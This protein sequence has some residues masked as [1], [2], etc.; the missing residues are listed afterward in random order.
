MDFNF[1]KIINR[2]NTNTKAIDI[3]PIPT[4][5]IKEGFSLIPMWVADMSFETVPTVIEEIENRINHSLFGYFNLPKEYFNSIINWQKNRNNIEDLKVGNIGYENGVLGGLSTSLRALASVGDSILVHSPTYIGFSR[6]LQNNGYNMVLSDLYLDEK[7]IWRMDYE[8]MERKIKENNIHLAIFCSP[9]N[10]SGRVWEREELEKAYQIF[11]ENNVYIISDEIWSDIILFNNF[12]I[13]SQ[14]ISQDAKNRTVSLYA[15]SKTFNLA[16]LV[17]SYH[18]VYNEYLKYK[19]DRESSLTFYNNPNVLS[20]SALIGA[21][22]KEGGLWLNELNSV[23]EKN[24]NYAYEFI[25]NNWEGVSLSKP[26]GTYLIYLNLEK[27]LED[28]SI[29]LDEILELGANYGVMW[30]DG[31]SF[32]FDNT[33]RMNLALPY[34]LV[35]EAFNRLDRF[36]FNIRN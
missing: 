27:Y 14:S 20:I 23:L 4:S 7:N 29:T 21:Y 9:H 10:P 12:H 6:V 3:N 16:G 33:I 2:Q 13:P 17:G 36:V 22:K 25:N 5:R 28:K 24:V 15:P 35:V 32:N 26:Q 30:Q 1:E 18:I 11:K 8:D 34:N 19:I 31:R